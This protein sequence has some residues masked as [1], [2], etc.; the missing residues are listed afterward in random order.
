MRSLFSGRGKD[1]PTQR[2]SFLSSVFGIKSGNAGKSITDQEKIAEQ[3][4]LIHTLRLQLQSHIANESSV[5]DLEH[6]EVFDE[7]SLN[8]GDLELTN[9]FEEIP[10]DMPTG[11]MSDVLTK[12]GDTTRMLAI[13]QKILSEQSK[14]IKKL[15]GLETKQ[16][17]SFLAVWNRDSVEPAY[18][19]CSHEQRLSLAM[20]MGLP[21]SE[22]IESFFGKEIGPN[23][24]FIIALRALT[25]ERIDLNAKDILAAY[26]MKESAEMNLNTLVTM[27]SS[28]RKEIFEHPFIFVET[29]LVE[30]KASLASNI[31]PTVLRTLVEDFSLRYLDPLFTLEQF[32]SLVLHEFQKHSNFFSYAETIWYRGSGKCCYRSCCNPAQSS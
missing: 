11:V 10:A 22:S 16:I 6:N 4:D 32:I 25:G 8:L 3:A 26:K 7:V 12:L 20:L 21:P 13:S 19:Q 14:G 1:Q 9:P 18:K 17:I 2:E 15:E 24:K 28:A 29:S 23:Q 27:L 31:Q 30:I 5:E